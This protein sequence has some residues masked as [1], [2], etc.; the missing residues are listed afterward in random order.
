MIY[1]EADR[2]WRARERR[3]WIVFQVMAMTATR[4]AGRVAGGSTGP[5]YSF[6]A[7]R[8]GLMLVR[9]VAAGR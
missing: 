8:G 2:A 9:G 5:G 3:L 7:C 4:L 6:L 1:A